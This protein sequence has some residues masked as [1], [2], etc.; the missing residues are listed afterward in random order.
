MYRSTLFSARRTASAGALAGMLALGA[1]SDAVRPIAGPSD[2]HLQIDND[3]ASLAARM[4]YDNAG[5]LDIEAVAPPASVASAV[6]ANSAVTNAAVV[7]ALSLTLQ[8][9]VA[10]PV[11]NG[12]PV[13]ATHVDVSGNYAVV[14]YATA[15]ESYGGAVALFDVSNTAR[16]TLVSLVTLPNADVNAVAFGRTSG[17]GSRAVTRIFLAEAT[18]DSGF[19]EGGVLERLDMVGGR[20]VGNSRRLALPSYAGT[21]VAVYAAYVFATSGTGGALMGGVTMV[22]GERMTAVAVDRFADARAM[23]IAP[24]ANLAIATQGT[25][26]RAR[27]YDMSTGQL[28][29]SDLM[30]GG[31]TGRAAKGNVKVVRDWAYVAAGDGGLRVLSIARRRVIDSIARPQVEGVAPEDQVTNAVTVDGDLA[32]IANGGAGVWIVS[33]RTDG[34]SSGTPAVSVLGRLRFSGPVSANFVASRNGTMFVAAGAGGLKIVR[35]TR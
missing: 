7:Q 19:V 1:C 24:E 31:S 27:L 33:T 28:R 21:G 29:I 30:V 20:I 10:P 26:G 6:V 2:L 12:V 11:V 25:P 16:P 5:P 35:V 8:A 4:R 13:Q 32:F 17:K 3:A 18:S 23:A 9:E 34:S 14:S 22:D 15:D